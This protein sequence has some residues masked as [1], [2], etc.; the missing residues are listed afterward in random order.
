MP[1][2][3]A[4]TTEPG[5]SH[6]SLGEEQRRRIG[7]RLQAVLLHLEDADLVGRAEAVLHRAQDAEGVA[8]VAL[9]V[10]HGVDHVLEHARPGEGAFLGDV[11]DEQAWRSSLRLANCT[12]CA[13]LSRTCPMLPGAEASC[14][15]NIVWIESIASTAGSTARA[16]SRIAS[17]FVSASTSSVSAR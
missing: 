11:A 15:V 8:A 13:A 12:S 3:L 1:S 6:R 4:T 9:E 5:T 10:E 7:H 14:S 17:T 16:C 2:M